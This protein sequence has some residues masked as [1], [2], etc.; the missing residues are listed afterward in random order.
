MIRVIAICVFVAAS[1]VAGCQTSVSR[2]DAIKQSL[3]T[4]EQALRWEKPRE[5]Y[6]FVHPDLQP[7]YPPPWIDSIRVVGYDVLDPPHEV[8]ENLVAQRVEVKYVNQD[9]QVMRTFIDE[10]LW[11]SDDGKKNWLRANPMP[12]FP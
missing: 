9:T 4:Y 5:A 6:R 12:A 10:Q 11:R 1:L 7:A 3:Y 8:G 2:K